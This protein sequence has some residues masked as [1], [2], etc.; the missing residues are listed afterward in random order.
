MG[1]GT[2]WWVSLCA[3]EGCT[4]RVRLCLVGWVRWRF[5]T[6]VECGGINTQGKQYVQKYPF[7][8]YIPLFPLSFSF[9]LYHPHSTNSFSFPPESP[10]RPIFSYSF[11]PFNPIWSVLHTSLHR[12][13][14]QTYSQLLNGIKCFNSF[15]LQR[16]KIFFVSQCMRISISQKI[17]DYKF[18]KIPKPQFP[19]RKSFCLTYISLESVF[20]SQHMI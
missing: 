7:T 8:V 13:S 14:T 2:E 6:G 17:Y 15:S 18:T 12:P 20:V 3:A 11:F 9:S 19:K 16:K 5:A 4:V 1:V 10:A